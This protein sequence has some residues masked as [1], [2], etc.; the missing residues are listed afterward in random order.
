VKLELTGVI[1][2]AFGQPVQCTWPEPPNVAALKWIVPS[3]RLLL[4]AEIVY[5]TNCD[6][7]G[8]FKA[9]VVDLDG[10]RVVKVLNQLEVKRR[11][12][13]DLGPFLLD[14]R[15]ECI[16]NPKSCRVAAAH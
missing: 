10:P 3:K 5:H 13:A 14:S 2:R 16:R 1:E 15:D 8:T 12:Q 7:Y 4:A 9:Y 11:Y 6:S